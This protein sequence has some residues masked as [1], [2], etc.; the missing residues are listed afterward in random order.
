MKICAIKKFFLENVRSGPFSQI[1]SHLF[2]Q[3]KEE[4]VLIVTNQ[5]AISYRVLGLQLDQEAFLKEAANFY[6]ECLSLDGSN[7]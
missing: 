3:S 6:Q 4:D 7:N 2:T 1:R 5:E